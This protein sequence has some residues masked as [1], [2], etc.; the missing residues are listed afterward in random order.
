MADPKQPS[1]EVWGKFV[2]KTGWNSKAVVFL[3]GLINPNFGFGVLDGAV[4][5]AE[6]CIKPTSVVPMATI[7]SVLTAVATTFFF[8]IPMLYCIN[9]IRLDASTKIG[10][11]ASLPSPSS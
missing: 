8:A 10:S 5:L 9:D 3:T 6:D 7:F 11:V 1:G 2:N 4:H